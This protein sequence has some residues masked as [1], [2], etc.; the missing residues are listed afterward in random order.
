MGKKISKKTVDK[1]AKEL[2]YIYK[3]QD[4]ALEVRKSKE[5]KG[6]IKQDFDASETE[7]ALASSHLND[8][9]YRIQYHKK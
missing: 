3:A 6:K 1:L 8:I 4:L 2:L 9:L 7:L 5:L